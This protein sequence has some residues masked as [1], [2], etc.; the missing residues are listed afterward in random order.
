MSPYAEQI[1]IC[2]GKDDWSSKIEDENE[3][4]NLA[5]DFK[6][7][8]SRGGVYADVIHSLSIIPGFAC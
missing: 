4:E 1:L 3:G 6:R 7:L 8:L 5:A 2:T